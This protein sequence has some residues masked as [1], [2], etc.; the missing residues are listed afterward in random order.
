MDLSNVTV[1]IPIHREKG[2]RDWLQETIASFPPGTA[3]VIAEND[4]ELAEA[5]NEAAK[6]VSTEWV[7][8]MG[9]DDKATPWMLETLMAFTENADVVYP[10]MLLT[11]ENAEEPLHFHPA[12]EFC[13]NRLMI[14]N[15]ISGCSLIRREA[16][17]SVG[18]FREL[19]WL[20]DWDLWV[21]MY[22]AGFRFKACP[23]AILNYRQVETSRNKYLDHDRA[24]IR[25]EAPKL[26][27]GEEPNLEATFY[28]QATPITS[29]LRCV[30]PARELPGQAVGPC[31]MTVDPDGTIEFPDHRGKA[32]VFQFAG[33]AVRAVTMMAMQEAGIK[34]LI[35]TDDNYLVTAGEISKRAGWG[36]KIGDSGHTLQGHRWIVENADGVIVTTE[37][38][39]RAYLRVNPNVFVCPNQ[40]DPVDWPEPEEREDDV[41]RIGWFASFS[42]QDDAKLVKRALDWASRQKNVEVVFVGMNPGWPMRHAHI[43]FVDDLALYRK[44]FSAIDVGV[45]PI[46]PTPFANCRSDVKALDYAMGGVCPVLSDTDSYSAWKDGENCF[47]A[48]D[49]KDFFHVIKHLVAN[50]DEAKQMARAA[51][52]YVLA[53]RTMKTNIW[54]WQEAIG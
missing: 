35:D 45:A 25:E 51:R 39:R 13:G 32:A 50:Q 52:D 11:D 53:E 29:Y 34:V 40:V 28:A 37:A 46:V 38:L 8:I 20:E 7:Y 36:K 17:L 48:A 43:P 12:D 1:I 19:P 2:R 41:F 3:Y 6:A 15:F 23:K 4:G 30:M 44:L 31:T 5:M 10:A 14:G 24:R 42:H 47:K 49:A 18:G 16:L 9:S 26:I 22:R 54:R 33:D 27:V 21:R